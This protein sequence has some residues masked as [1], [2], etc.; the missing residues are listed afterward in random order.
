MSKVINLSVDC[1]ILCP[2]C[3]PKPLLGKAP[4]NCIEAGKLINGGNVIEVG[5]PIPKW[6]PLPDGNKLRYFVVRE[7][8]EEISDDEAIPMKSIDTVKLGEETWLLRTHE[9]D[10]GV[11]LVNDIGE[12]AEEC[13]WHGIQKNEQQKVAIILG[14]VITKKEVD[15]DLKNLKRGK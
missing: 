9:K 6:C 1:C 12:V 15:L 4:Y 3:K 14:R 13:N 11:E 2:Y 10:R 7:Q 8:L 5:T